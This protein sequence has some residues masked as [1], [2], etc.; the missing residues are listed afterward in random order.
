MGID[1][2]SKLDEQYLE[3]EF[4]KCRLRTV[5]CMRPSVITKGC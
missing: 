3:M 2:G 1:K 5:S 4:E